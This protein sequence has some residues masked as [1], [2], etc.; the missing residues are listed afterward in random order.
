ML[1]TAM[2]VQGDLHC[3]AVGLAVVLASE[4]FEA[5]YMVLTQALLQTNLNLIESLYIL[6]P[7]VCA[8]LFSLAAVFEWP[9]MIQRGHY[10]SMAIFPIQFIAAAVIVCAVNVLSIAVVQ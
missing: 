3:T 10:L 4:A 9:Q 7:P 6:T 2:V 5:M 8:C 1:G